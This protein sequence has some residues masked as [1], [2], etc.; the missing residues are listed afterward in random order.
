MS[1]TR[2]RCVCSQ[3]VAT[4]LFL[5]GNVLES[6]AANSKLSVICVST[7][8]EPFVIEQEGNI[9]GIDIDVVA[10]IGKRININFTF[11]LKPW[12]RIGKR[13]KQGK[14]DCVIA[15][16]KTP[17]REPYL[18]YTRMPIHITQ[19]TLFVHKENRFTYSSL[20]DLYQR[21]I[22]VNRGFK[23]TPAFALAVAEQKIRQVDVREDAQSFGLLKRKRIDA[24][25]TNY[26][27]GSYMVKQRGYDQ[28]IPINPPLSST[29]AYV[30]FA[31]KDHL[32]AII[33]LF[34]SA[35]F[36]ILQDGTY[37]KIF[38]QYINY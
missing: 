16:F 30:V 22:A 21:S 34:D 10:A 32:N 29:P 38:S 13:V 24:V 12:K 31:K 18:H 37:Q 33:P 9:K 8:Y 36:S 1:I 19:Y 14:E 6:T 4:G 20:E 15:Y 23:T 5:F 3:L 25:L 26:H 2:C 11:V 28:I 17:D 27:V 35:L 7:V